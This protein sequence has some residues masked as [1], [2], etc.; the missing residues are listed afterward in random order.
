MNVGQLK[1]LLDGLP[2]DV[3]VCRV[4]TQYLMT[5]RDEFIPIRG[6]KIET[7]YVDRTGSVNRHDSS[8][9]VGA[10]RTQVLTIVN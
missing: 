2:D 6:M 1:Q 8:A 9:P 10:D 3:H 7:G 5:P 4:V